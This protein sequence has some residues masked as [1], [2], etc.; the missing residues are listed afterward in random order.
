MSASHAGLS[1]RG[2]VGAVA[3]ACAAVSVAGA[4]PRASLADGAVGKLEEVRRFLSE[5]FSR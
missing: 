3:L 1:R 5:V 4:E 2:W